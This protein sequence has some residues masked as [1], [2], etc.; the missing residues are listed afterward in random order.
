MGGK[1]VSSVIPIWPRDAVDT[2]QQFAAETDQARRFCR[3]CGRSRLVAII[4]ERGI[5]RYCRLG[6]P[7]PKLFSRSRFRRARWMDAAAVALLMALMACLGVI[8][9][10][11]SAK[12]DGYMSDDEQLF[13]DIY[14]T[15]VCDTLDDYRSIAGVV[16]VVQG[17]SE[18][19]FH[20][21]D[22]VDIVNYSVATYCPRHWWLLVATGQAARGGA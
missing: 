1:P 8:T 22:S 4:D 17:V 11:A 14:Y 18:Q 13:A 16:G 3:T 20:M 9:F 12:A 15:A 2:A 21:T 7:V 5:C 10:A 6:L 19:G